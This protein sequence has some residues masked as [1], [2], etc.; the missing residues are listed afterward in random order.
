VATDRSRLDAQK[1]AARRNLPS[2]PTTADFP[3]T[4]MRLQQTLG[5]RGTQRFLERTGRPGRPGATVQSVQRMLIGGLNKKK[6]KELVKYKPGE[7]LTF[8]EDYRAVK[9]HDLDLAAIGTDADGFAF[10]FD[11]LAKQEDT[12]FADVDEFIREVTILRRHWGGQ[13]IFY[14]KPDKGETTTYPRVEGQEND[15]IIR[16][17]SARSLVD[18]QNLYAW[19]LANNI[20]T[21]GF[22]GVNP[23][24]NAVTAPFKG[25]LGDR[26]HTVMHYN[27]KKSSGVRLIGIVLTQAGSNALR[28]RKA[29]PENIA[30]GHAEGYVT[31]QFG[32]KAE[33]TYVSVAL[34]NA[35]ATW[36]YLKD[37]IDK[38]VLDPR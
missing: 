4:M 34:S 28:A 11:V 20:T 30:V 16:L 26:S 7:R 37:K 33:R 10:L 32:L 8:L 25:H 31:G 3:T 18:V 13:K 2:T 5:N 15:D 24:P 1:Q 17:Y 27:Q 9:G 23:A 22:D 36:D 21:E 6:R 29:N 35:K 12:K 14:E 19:A 38:I